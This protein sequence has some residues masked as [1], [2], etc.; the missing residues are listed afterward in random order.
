MIIGDYWF[1]TLMVDNT[2]LVVNCYKSCMS[3]LW[4]ICLYFPGLSAQLSYAVSDYNEYIGMSI[5]DS[6]LVQMV[7]HSSSNIVWGSWM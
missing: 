4:F 6:K 5:L 1:P 2:L 3:C 7:K